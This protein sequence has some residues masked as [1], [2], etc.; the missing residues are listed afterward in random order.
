MTPED[1]S[2]TAYFDHSILPTASLTVTRQIEG[3]EM[4]R[5]TIVAQAETSARTL[6]LFRE[7]L[8][9]YKDWRV[10]HGG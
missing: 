4:E 3:T 7:I 1:P 5:T 10:D 9:D 8:K 2:P 6:E